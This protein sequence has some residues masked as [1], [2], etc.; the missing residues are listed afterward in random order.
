MQAL[1][2]GKKEKGPEPLAP[3]E[4]GITEDVKKMRFASAQD[5]G[6]PPLD[7]LALGGKIRFSVHASLKRKL[8]AVLVG[9]TSILIILIVVCALV[10][11][12]SFA[13]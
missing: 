1:S 13:G 11:S 5:R 4:D 6:Q 3:G 2:R 12:G 10:L 8:A 9:G 7:G